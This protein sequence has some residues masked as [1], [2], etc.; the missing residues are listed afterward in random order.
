VWAAHE[1]PELCEVNAADPFTDATLAYM[2]PLDDPELV[3]TVNAWLAGT[4]DDGT[5]DAAVSDWFGDDSVFSA[6][7]LQE[8]LG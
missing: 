8:T 6:E 1:H 5:W 2:L 3:D 4:Y 7:Q